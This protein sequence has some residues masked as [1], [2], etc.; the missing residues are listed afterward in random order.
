MSLLDRIIG[1]SVP[2]VP[3][4]IVRRIAG[5]YIAGET[6]DDLVRTVEELNEQGFMVA[7]SILGE[8]V[9]RKAESEDAVRQYEE[10]LETIA[11]LQLDSN[12][13]VKLTHLGLTLDKEFCCEN[14]RRLLR[15]AG[16]SNNFMRID[17]EDSACTDDTLELHRR[18]Q[19]EFDNVGVVIQACMRRSVA[20]VRGLAATR[21]NVRLCKGIYIEPRAIAYRDR[22]VIR[23]NY[24]WLL[25]QLLSAGCYVGIATHDEWLVHEAFRTISRRGLE[26][27]QYE[28]Q[29]LHGVDPELRRII[30]GE[31]HRLRVA[32]PFGPSWYPYSVRRLR[33]NPTIARYV[34]QALLRRS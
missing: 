8:F 13:H 12:I 27:S 21:A 14:V 17:M 19:Q 29:M 2:L 9:T 33:K 31:G 30:Q 5:P 18:L 11:R 1:A 28:F 25:D 26:P 6:L 23:R 4:P 22:E 32:V 7:T 16:A 3:K 24:A 10:V 15:K 34:L 20:D